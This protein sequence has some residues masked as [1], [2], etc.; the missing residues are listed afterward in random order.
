ML[1][2][3]RVEVTVEVKEDT[4]AVNDETYMGY[5]AEHTHTSLQSL[6]ANRAYLAA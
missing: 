3:V 6:Y 5:T 1:T 2:S 4:V